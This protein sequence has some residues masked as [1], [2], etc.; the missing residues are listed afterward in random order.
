MV[1]EAGSN[2]KQ[3]LDLQGWGERVID[4]LIVDLLSL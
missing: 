4:L 2:N 3:M 1:G